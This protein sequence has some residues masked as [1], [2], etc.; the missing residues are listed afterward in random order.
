MIPRVHLYTVCWDE[1][2][3]LGFFFRHYDPW[4]ERYVVYDDGS[5]D[6]SL[7]ILRAHPRVELRRFDRVEAESFVLSHKAMQD[8]A[9]KESR[10]SADWI[11][12]TAIDEHLH[13]GAGRPMA[14]YLDEQ[15]RAG[16]TLLPALG[17]DMNHPTMPD[18]CGLLV[19][20]VTRGR[21][22]PA[23]NKLSLFRPRAI[24]ETGFGPGRHA[25]APIGDLRLPERDAVMLWHYKHLGFERNA[26][27]EASQAERLGRVDI[28]SGFGQHYLRSRAR[29]RGFWD[30][31]ERDAADLS[32]PGF[33]PESACAR[34]LW[35]E[36]RSGMIR[37]GTRPPRPP[38]PA[39]VLERPTVSVLIKAHEHA[40]YVRQCIDSV[41]DQSFADVEIVVTDD[42]STDGTAEILRGYD[43]PRIRLAVQP[44]NLGI[45]ATMNATVARARGRYL[46]ILNSDD[47]ALPGRLARQ[48]AFLDAN[49][50]V[51]LVFGLPRVVDEGGAPAA[52]FNDFLRPLA[53]PDF[54]R[55]TW[56]RSF[57]REGNSLC[58]PAAMIRREAYAA[59]GPY[60]P[61]LTNLQ[62]LDMWVRMVAAGH[63]IHVLPEEVTAFRQRAGHA[64]MSAPRPDTRLRTGFEFTKILR[65]FAALDPAAF[66]EAFGED[67]P[68][69]PFADAPV[70][71]RLAALAARDTRIACLNFAVEHAYAS[72]RD[73]DGYDRLRA[74]SGVA[75][76]LGLEAI[77]TR[78][79]VLACV[80]EELAEQERRLENVAAELAE[81]RGALSGRDA[82]S[83]RLAADL[84]GARQAL[85]GCDIRLERLATDLA[86]AEERSV[87][88][89][90]QAAERG[91]RLAEHEAALARAG[92]ESIRRAAEHLRVEADLRAG[93]AEALAERDG[94]RR[95][96]S[97]RSTAILR[98]LG[99]VVGR[100]AR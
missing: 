84:A 50:D 18:D 65:H 7:D 68:E 40:P 28:A 97:W 23:F 11:V 59:A 87:R 81:A 57:F 46:A 73:A 82:R 9:W 77:A 55:R 61:R 16:V 64:N 19:E 91:Q 67:L 95:S 5:T 14:P 3:M 52:P 51:S 75:D 88:A 47:F 8:E 48:A 92:D 69:G 12:V 63:A 66:E 24:R 90:A 31:M 38:V 60:D 53:F 76:A 10:E 6:G 72:A 21:P 45:S 20:R 4:V 62:D 85:A 32:A 100:R 36:E 83:E 44:R 34:P 79:H 96:L 41:L 80:R 94:M 27:R 22:R 86:A 70:A 29:L 15:A 99:H 39:S 56:L 71:D 1:A 58:A 25:A 42:A 13:L 89:E 33:A 37:A 43:D 30:E 35:W 78:D 98:R 54:S 2:D 17:F 93:L 26:A 49:P 74:V